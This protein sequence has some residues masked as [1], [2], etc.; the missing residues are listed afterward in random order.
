M[1]LRPKQVYFL[2]EIPECLIGRQK[3]HKDFLNN[4]CNAK[5]LQIEHR[6]N[7]GC[8]KLSTTE[9][10]LWNNKPF[11]YHIISCK[12]NKIRL[13]PDS[14]ALSTTTPSSFCLKLDKVSW[15]RV[16]L[17]KKFVSRTIKVL[18]LLE[19]CFDLIS[20]SSL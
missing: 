17:E 8:L 18:S 3:D 2:N 13:L 16:Q 4:Y 7:K 12:L 6:T 19:A 10:Y 5:L 20:G 11:I 14:L 1:L 9:S 15:V